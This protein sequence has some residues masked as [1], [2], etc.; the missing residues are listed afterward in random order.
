MMVHEPQIASLQE[1]QR[2]I[3]RGHAEAALQS[4]D[5][6]LAGNAGYARA[7]AGRGLALAA[8]G[9]I[10]E[11][12]AAYVLAAQLDPGDAD[13]FIQVGHLMLRLGRMGNAH[14]AF[15]AALGA[16]AR[17]LEALEGCA[18]ALTAMSRHEEAAE[19]FRELAALL[20][21]D[22][23]VAGRWFHA[24]LNCCDWNGY[25]AA[26]ASLAAR[27]A[28][29]E[30]ADDPFS[31]LAHNESPGDQR[32]RAE[33]EIAARYPVKRPLGLSPRPAHARLRVAYLSADFRAHPVAQL[34]APVLEQHDRARFEIYALSA[35]ADDGSELRRRVRSACEHF[36]EITSLQDAALAHRIA[37]L[38]IDI[39][40]D[41]GGHTQGSRL[42]V[43]AFRPAP[44]QIA[45]L[46][47]PGTTGAGFID[48]LIADRRVI[49]EA[50]RRH[51]REQLIYLPSSY[52]PLAA[53]PAGVPRLER[54]AAGLPADRFV[55]CSFNAP[56][57]YTPRMY[58]VWMRILRAVPEG[59][60]WLRDVPDGVKQTLAREAMSRGIDAARLIFAPRTAS[61]AEHHAR[62]GLADLFLDTHPYGAH[63]TASDALGAEV[64][65][66][67]LMGETFCSRVAMSLLHS[68]GLSELA[69]SDAAD[70]ERLAIG[71][72]RDPGRLQGLRSRLRGEEVRAAFDPRRFCRHLEQAYLDVWER[73]QHG[74]APQ[75]L[76]VA[77][78]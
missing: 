75:M 65:V 26:R 18:V 39:A 16:R 7:H 25:D 69:V 13:T 10:D 27:V 21:D 40:V 46:G 50:Q 62:L 3:E 61:A 43:L 45:Y 59:I 38:E 17:D 53:L 22:A 54:A 12:L 19:R 9:R 63:T 5:R 42:R 66:I 31:F 68:V 58:A 47:F 32:R 76:E 37:E 34:L 48:Y 55:F 49:P 24:R 35:G 52:L 8:L 20:P 44:I 6:A 28:R 67:T 57:K 56:Y 29:G 36:L 73:R 51:Y 15:C 2:L 4:F 60:L 33:I 72:A 23:Q 14:A 41:L 64:P 30:P 74:A 71:L 70:Y 77:H 78:V 1:G 11:S